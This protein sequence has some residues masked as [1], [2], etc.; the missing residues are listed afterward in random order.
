M[1]K[2]RII[3]DLHAED[4]ERWDDFGPAHGPADRALIEFVE[5]TKA[6]G[7]KIIIA[8]DW[9]EAQQRL[10]HERRRQL[11]VDAVMRAH[12]DAMDALLAETEAIVGGNHDARL[13]GMK[14]YG[15]EILPYFKDGDLWVEHGH[16]HDK[17]VSRWPHFCARVADAVGWCERLIDT[18]FDIWAW[19]AWAWATGTGRHGESAGYLDT[20][21]IRALR[22]GCHTAVFGHTHDWMPP[23]MFMG[24]GIQ[25]A[26]P[27]T[28]G[29]LYYATA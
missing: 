13:L 1:N 4:G 28:N 15:L 20:V 18:N 14:V 19:N 24:V 10:R 25:N 8:G 7:Q 9:I 22:H 26:G 2:R 17:F 11:I 6:K 29:Q 5:E 27:R 16:Y 23:T 21:A 12:G 3:A